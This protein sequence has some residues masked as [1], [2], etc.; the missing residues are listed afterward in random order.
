MEEVHAELL[1]EDK[2][3]LVG[4]L[5]SRE[6]YTA[7]VGDGMNDA[8]A[9]A[10]ANVGI[11]MGISGSAVAME[12]SH[13]TLMSNDIG[14]IV[15]AI[16]LARKM[17]CKIITNITFSL[18]TKIAI[19]T[20]AFAG[21][22]LLWAAVLADVGTCLLVISNSMMLLKTKTSSS[23]KCC[24]SSHKTCSGKPKNACGSS[25]VCGQSGCHDHGTAKDEIILDHH[26]RA[27]SPCH[28]HCDHAQGVDEESVHNHCMDRDHQVAESHCHSP[29]GQAMG[30]KASST[31]TQEHFVSIDLWQANVGSQNQEK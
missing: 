2:V 23:K 13:I 30:I 12:T 31:S 19:L 20:L 11:S 16:R 6:G 14:K 7:M 5:K 27:E 18:V 9:L 8:P 29:C 3:K 24:A 26:H 28:S 15:K 17:R 4:D 22:S 10:L 25:S 1:P 21:H